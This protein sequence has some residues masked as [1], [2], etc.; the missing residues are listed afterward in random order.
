MDYLSREITL[1]EKNIDD[2]V[3]RDA[4]LL[5]EGASGKVYSYMTKN[6]E[7]L[8]IKMM[9]S[10]EWKSS[11]E[12]YKDIVWQSMIHEEINKLEKS[13]KVLGYNEYTDTDEKHY[14]CFI[15]EF[16][17][18]YIDCFS[19]V[20]ECENWSRE[21][22]SHY[23]RKDNL[24]NDT[25]YIVDRKS[26]IRI[27][28]NMITAL[29]EIHEM[30]IIHGDIKTNNI[31]INSST[32]DVKF[33]DFGA[34]LFIEDNRKYMETD[35]THG[36]LGYRAPE[37]DHSNLLGKTSDI[38]SLGVTIIELW[39]G[40][41]WYSGETFRETRNEVLKSMRVIEKH[42]KELGCIIRKCLNIDGARRPTVQK[43]DSF[44][45]SYS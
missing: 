30:D 17:E 25:Y 40:D 15:M 27:I 43:L 13:V 10:G 42:E 14:V 22:V 9:Y 37:E 3:L 4:T 2:F 12:F 7:K 34:S 16:Y 5:G 20:D 41:I 44:F 36:T 8:I 39:K 33:I 26:K 18:G 11:D 38:Y 23:K 21:V 28:K 24:K 45:Q 19:F 29:K 1:K 35:W 31:I 32:G 6:D